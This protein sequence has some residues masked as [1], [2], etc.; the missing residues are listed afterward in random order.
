MLRHKPVDILAFGNAPLRNS[1]F[2][3]SR[4]Q[5]RANVIGVAADL[6]FVVAPSLDSA[7]SPSGIG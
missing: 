3:K 7:M 2:A 4:F 1:D 6:P 5:K